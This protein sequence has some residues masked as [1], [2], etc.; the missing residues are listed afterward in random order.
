MGAPFSFF[1]SVRHQIRVLTKNHIICQTSVNMT[2]CCKKTRSKVP[3]IPRCLGMCR[4]I[5]LSKITHQMWL[6]HP[7]SQRNKATKRAVGV[8]VGENLNIFKSRGK[9]CNYAR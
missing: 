6:G 1:V 8:G 9:A 5:I 7:F 4:F 2:P 3:L